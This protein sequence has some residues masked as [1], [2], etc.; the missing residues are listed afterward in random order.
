MPAT[1]RWPCRSRRAPPARVT[2]SSSSSWSSLVLSLCTVGGGT[3]RPP[4]PLR[5]EHDNRPLFER[6]AARAARLAENVGERGERLPLYRGRVAA[7][8][9]VAEIEL[10]L[11]HG[12]GRFERDQRAAIANRHQLHA[13][14][15]L[16]LLC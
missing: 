15:P 11:W 5:F 6:H 8:D 3:C 12:V 2:S 14:Q 10:E 13:R 9:R 1:W 4:D 7:V 16:Q